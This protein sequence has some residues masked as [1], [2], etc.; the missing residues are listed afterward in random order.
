MKKKLVFCCVSYSLPSCSCW[1][2]S[3]SCFLLSDEFQNINLRQRPVWPVS[4]QCRAFAP[5]ARPPHKKAA[6]SDPVAQKMTQS[7]DGTREKVDFSSTDRISCNYHRSEVVDSRR[8]KRSDEL[9]P[10]FLRCFALNSDGAKMATFHLRDDEIPFLCNR[11]RS[12]CRLVR[13]MWS[14]GL[15]RRASK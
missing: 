8:T 9:C 3:S 5:P 11:C 13:V 1:R 14:S 4:P 6:G 15:S 12:F 2:F 10:T 7:W